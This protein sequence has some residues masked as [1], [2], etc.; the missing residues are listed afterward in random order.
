MESLFCAKALQT[1]NHTGLAEA[2]YV[3]GGGGG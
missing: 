2:Q 1:D 3:L